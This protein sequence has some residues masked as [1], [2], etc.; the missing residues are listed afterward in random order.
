M[1]AS[2]CS[3]IFLI[4]STSAYA[5]KLLD[6]MPN[7]CSLFASAILFYISRSLSFARKFS[8]FFFSIAIKYETYV[9]QKVANPVIAC[10]DFSRFTFMHFDIFILPESFSAF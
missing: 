2:L 5:L 4:V 9:I 10:N 7:R 8:P 3:T 6:F 1:W